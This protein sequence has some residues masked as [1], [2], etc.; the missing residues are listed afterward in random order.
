[1]FKREKELDMEPI[2][3]D[4]KYNCMEQHGEPNC[5]AYMAAHLLQHY[6]IIKDPDDIYLRMGRYMDSEAVAPWQIATYLNKTFQENSIPIKY[7][8]KKAA[9]LHDIHAEL[10]RGVPVPVLI[11]YDTHSSSFD[12]LHYVLVTGIDDKNVYLIDSLSCGG[13]CTYNRTVQIKDFMKMWS[14]EKFFAPYKWVSVRN[15]MLACH[16]II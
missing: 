10:E 3:I 14:L 15:F 8:F 1:M 12:D 9:V 4:R 7:G 11:L 6:G 2:I 13:T 16:D 5:S